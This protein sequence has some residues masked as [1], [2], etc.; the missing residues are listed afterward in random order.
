MCRQTAG[1]TAPRPDSV[2][3][4]NSS[5]LFLHLLRLLEGHGKPTFCGAA[6]QRSSTR[7][8]LWTPLKLKRARA[9][10]GELPTL[11]AC[12]DASHTGITVEP[13]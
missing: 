10:H 5:T 13:R 2:T 7:A 3:Q 8:G 11:S 1:V 6:E 12:H 4:P 9:Y